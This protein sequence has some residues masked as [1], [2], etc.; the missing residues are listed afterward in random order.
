MNPADLKLS[1]FPSAD[2]HMAALKGITDPE[3]D[4]E[5]SILRIHV[6]IVLVFI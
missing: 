1:S 4:R 5:N 3:S 6:R 2:K